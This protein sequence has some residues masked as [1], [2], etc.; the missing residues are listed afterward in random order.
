[1]EFEKICFVIM[2]FGK[3]KI[4]VARGSKGKS[5]E[6]T[7][8]TRKVD[9][10]DIY[11]SIFLPAIENVQLREGGHL[12]A[13]RT[14]KAFFSGDITQEMFEYIEYSRFALADITGL[15]ANVF[16]EL[17]ARHRA[18]ESGT[19]IFRQTEVPIPFD[20]SHIKAFPYEYRPKKKAAEARKTITRILTDSLRLN[21][22]D[23]P[24][25]IAL[26]AQRNEGVNVDDLLREAENAIRH[27]DQATA[28]MKYEEALRKRPGDPLLHFRIGSLLKDQGMFDGAREHFS[29]AIAAVPDYAEA[30]RELGVVEN[31][32]YRQEKTPP[33]DM[34][35]GQAALKKAIALNPSDF[36]ALASLG[37]TLK[38]LGRFGE[39]H[40][41]YRRSR[42][43]SHG[44]SYPLLN[45]IKLEARATGK[46]NVD[47]ERRRQLARAERPLRVQVMD[48]PPYNAPWSLFDLAE[49]RLYDGD[50]NEFQELLGKGLEHCSAPWMAQ[51][52]L[53]SLQLLVD[54]GVELPGLSRGLERLEKA[55]GAG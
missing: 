28:R 4:R 34:P 50:A 48:E 31:Q 39:A 38:R 2:P 55:A 40:E 19:A 9:F 7:T 27:E 53:D 36:D 29:K 3:K 15:N 32:I 49:V 30:Y 16:Y 44:H 43:V 35:D 18:Q 1:M 47:E 22:L 41:M 20:I 10:D 12:V 23:S 52:F 21:R 5:G 37:G 42:E 26:R 46:L 13:H 14:D 8:K 51:T 17:G 6:S 33:A 45:E 24:I 11:D 25:R 54:G